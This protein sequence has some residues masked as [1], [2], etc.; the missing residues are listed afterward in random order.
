MIKKQ[1]VKSRDLAK[2]FGEFRC[3]KGGP[4]KKDVVQKEGGIQ[5]IHQCGIASFSTV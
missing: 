5:D 4:I 1:A 2:T 3:C